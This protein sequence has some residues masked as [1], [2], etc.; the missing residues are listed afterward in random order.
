MRDTKNLGWAGTNAVRKLRVAK[1]RHGHPFMINSKELPVGQC[2]LEYPSG[3]IVLA[4]LSKTNQ[5]FDIVRE[6]GSIEIVGIRKKFG[7]EQVSE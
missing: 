2:Y 6:L 3:S 5:D 7:L 1:L 4:T